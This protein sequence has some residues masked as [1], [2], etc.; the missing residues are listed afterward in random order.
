[1]P[2]KRPKPRDIREQ[3]QKIRKREEEAKKSEYEHRQ[4]RCPSCNDTSLVFHPSPT[5]GRMMIYCSNCYCGDFLEL[6]DGLEQDSYYHQF[7]DHYHKGEHFS[8]RQPS[9][10]S[11]EKLREEL[12][13]KLEALLERSGKDW[14][15]ESLSGAIL[16]YAAETENPHSLILAR[17]DFQ[18]LIRYYQQRQ[19]QRREQM[20]RKLKEQ[21]A[22]AESERLKS[23]SNE[24]KER[25][26]E[27]DLELVMKQLKEA[28]EQIRR[29]RELEEERERVRGKV[30]RGGCFCPSDC[31]C[32]RGCKNL[33]RV[34][35]CGCPCKFGNI[36]KVEICTS[37]SPT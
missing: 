35:D 21:R 2:A 19:E 9:F 3:E 36:I 34:A 30:E 24:E 28:A 26:M 10:G 27:K 25:E 12:T 32:L 11:V 15:D 16:S 31:I 4:P 13:R 1:M 37:F 14:T 17:D 7:V 20:E 8:G 29:A 22:M 33:G 5:L 23:L 6:K 18:I